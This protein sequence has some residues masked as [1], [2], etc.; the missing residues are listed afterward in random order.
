MK[1]KKNPETV[2]N[3]NEEFVKSKMILYGLFSQNLI[4]IAL[5]RLTIGNYPI[6]AEKSYAKAS[7]K[8]LNKFTF[9]LRM[10]LLSFYNGHT[11][12]LL[13]FQEKTIIG[14][15]FLLGNSEGFQSTMME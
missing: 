5:S 9:Q 15:D 4:L 7:L 10:T 6:N 2:S 8:Y 14:V 1:V 13:L 12:R 3:I 11:L